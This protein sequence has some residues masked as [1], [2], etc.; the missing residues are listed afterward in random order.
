MAT[1]GTTTF[2]RVYLEN[3][4]AILRYCISQVGNRHTAED[5]AGDTFASAWA[6]IG[7]DGWPADIRPWLFRI[8]RNRVIDHSR[9][10][11]RARRALA[12]LMLQ[13]PRGRDVEDAAL[14]NHDLVRVVAAVAKLSERDKT[15]LGLRLAGGLSH[16]QIASVLGLAED[17]AR[18]GSARALARLRE[19]AKEVDRGD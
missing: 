5:I 12:R 11:A 4:D 8:A 17:A 18:Q 6:A 3:R 7:R 2:D 1:S 13:S 10:S 16:A 9:R 15:I 19:A 14:L